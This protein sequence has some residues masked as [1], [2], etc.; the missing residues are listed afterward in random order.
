[1]KLSNLEGLTSTNEEYQ[2]GILYYYPLGYKTMRV[3][4]WSLKNDDVLFEKPVKNWNDAIAGLCTYL[5]ITGVQ[6]VE[7]TVKNLMGRIAE[8][9]E[10][11]LTL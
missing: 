7:E 9:S 8:I 10:K 11:S 6:N 2:L 5:H 3:Q 4:I 1:M